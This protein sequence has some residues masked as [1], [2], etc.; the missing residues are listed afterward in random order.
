M[1]KYE[2]DRIFTQITAP[3]ELE[4]TQKRIDAFTP[5]ARPVPEGLIPKG[6]PLGHIALRG[7]FEPKRPDQPENSNS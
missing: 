2:V 5:E 1:R 3:L 6:I 7:D 4:N